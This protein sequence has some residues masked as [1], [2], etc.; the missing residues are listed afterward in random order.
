MM[1]E[2]DNMKPEDPGILFPV[3]ISRP[4]KKTSQST[5]TSLPDDDNSLIKTSGSPV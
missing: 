2:P 4:D 3:S 1:K 5:F